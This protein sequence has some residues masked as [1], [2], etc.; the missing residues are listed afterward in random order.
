MKPMN[1]EHLA[2]LRRHMVEVV[3]IYAD[4]ASEELGK[5]ALDERVMAAM[6]RVPRHLF[7]PVPAAPFA[8]Q[9]MPLPIGF[10]KTVSQPFMVALMTDLLAP[11]PHEAVLEIGTGLGYQTAILAQ[12]AGQVWSVEIIEEFAG[13]AEALLHGLGMSNV[14]IRIGDGSRGWP[15]HAPFDKI[16][17]TAAAEQP[18]PALLEQLKPMGRLVLPVGSEEQVLTVIDKDSAGR[19]AARQLIPVRFSRLEAA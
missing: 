5:A 8:Y 15:E 9:D 19:F 3:A 4:L 17:V 12:L 18:P 10:D 6:L 13:Q 1:E 2:V 11:Q 16:L 14:G 7:V